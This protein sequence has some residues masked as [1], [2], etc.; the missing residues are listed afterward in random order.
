MEAGDLGFGPGWLCLSQKDPM[1]GGNS[2]SR[3][4]L[5]GRNSGRCRG[6]QKGE[7]ARPEWVLG[8]PWEASPF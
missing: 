5:T 4:V 1:G 3:P 6:K 8:P 2:E 7:M